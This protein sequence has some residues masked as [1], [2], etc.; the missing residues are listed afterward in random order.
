[1]GH[2]ADCRRHAHGTMEYVFVSW[3]HM[4]HA[5]HNKMGI[6]NEE[7]SEPADLQMETKPEDV[8]AEIERLSQR[9]VSRKKPTL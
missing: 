3:L 4:L 1:M 7:N 6:E 8:L 9:A 2:S 5:I